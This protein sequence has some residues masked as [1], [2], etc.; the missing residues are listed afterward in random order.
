MNRMA[1]LMVTLSVAFAACFAQHGSAGSGYFP[2]GYAG[3]TW[4]GTVTAVN[5]DTREITLT[6]KANKGEETFTGVLRPGY[7]VPMKDGTRHEVE[8]TDIPIGSYLLVYYMDKSKKADG[9]KIH[10]N[11]IF[12]FRYW[13]T[14]PD[15]ID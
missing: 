15:K 13:K 3:D 1:L 5:P 9:K 11:E 6:A 14:Q 10:Y 12:Q 7:T 2:M 4:K 8:M